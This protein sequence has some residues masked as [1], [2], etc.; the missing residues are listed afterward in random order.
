MST[1]SE[2]RMQAQ[3]QRSGSTALAAALA[4]ERAFVPRAKLSRPTDWSRD[5][6]G[7]RSVELTSEPLAS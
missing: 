1:Q 6:L 3:A 4:C 2:G 7:S 5:A